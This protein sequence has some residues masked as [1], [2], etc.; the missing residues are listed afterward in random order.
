[1]LRH[2]PPKQPLRLPQRR[3]LTSRVCRWLGELLHRNC[4]SDQNTPTQVP[5]S[6]LPHHHRRPLP[7]PTSNKPEAWQ[8]LYQ[9][10]SALL[11]DLSVWAKEDLGLT[12]NL[13]KCSLLLPPHAPPPASHIQAAFPPGFLFNFDGI[14]VA[15]A[16]IGTDAFI[17]SF[18]ETKLLEVKTKLH[19]IKLLSKLATRAAHR[20]LT[21]RATS[22]FSYIATTTP[23]S[24]TLPYLARFDA[25]VEATFFS[26]LE[27]QPDS[28]SVQRQTRAY[29]KASLPAPEG[30]GL[31]KAA[32]HAA[33]AWWSSV[34]NA[35]TD[36]LVYELRQGLEHFASPA[37]SLIQRAL[38][39]SH[40]SYWTQLSF[41]FPVSGTGLTDGATYTPDH[42]PTRQLN[43]I[44]LKVIRKRSR[45]TFNRLSRPLHP[46]QSQCGRRSS[47]LWCGPH[48]CRASE[49]RVLPFPRRRLHRLH[50]LLPQFTTPHHPQQRKRT[51]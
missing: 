10:Y 42:P 32:D 30:C 9:T 2:R 15:G 33:V 47:T 31:L 11:R 25:E 44:T 13:G 28:C 7:P 6:P 26:I 46:D 49:S 41:N 18:L 36:P 17:N 27:L 16:P 38:G 48:F 1:M 5:T 4:T 14:P 19:S 34:A 24:L 51:T 3:R 23:P 22:L 50:A 39:G 37:F 45:S 21:S 35:M 40:S 12:L 29:L 43:K 20:L 8:A